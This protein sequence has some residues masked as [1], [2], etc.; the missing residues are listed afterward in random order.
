MRELEIIRLGR[1]SYRAGLELMESRLAQRM[2]GEVPDC[3]FLLEHDPVLTMGRRT[4]KENILASPERLAAMGIEVFETGRGGDVT[5]HGPGQIVGYPI[6]DL[7]PHRKDVR[8]YVCDLEA[9][10]IAV[11]AR[12]GVKTGRYPGHIGCWIDEDRKI[13][14]VGVRISRWFTSHG[15]A[16]NVSSNLDAFQLI[17]PCGIRDKGVTSLSA[18]V[19]R[20]VPM[21]AVYDDFEAE[22]RACFSGMDERRSAC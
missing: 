11:A 9:V 15:F 14:A 18:E 17:V 5:Y 8:K 7:S 2:K 4:A 16:F 22:L 20:D 21:A 19:G 10:M 13:G 1:I 3:V 12:H 6:L